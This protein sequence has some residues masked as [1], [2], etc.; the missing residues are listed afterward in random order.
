MW[1]ETVDLY[2]TQAFASKFLL[3]LSILDMFSFNMGLF[4][5]LGYKETAGMCYV[6]ERRIE[7]VTQIFTG[8]VQQD[9]ATERGEC[10]VRPREAWFYFLLTSQTA[11]VFKLRCRGW[12][13]KRFS[14]D[15]RKTNTKVNTPTNYNGSKQ[16]DEPIRF[17]SNYTVL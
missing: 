8:R 4:V 5:G 15:C 14:N 12:F 11:F 7:S 13:I 2:R 3:T 9:L 10:L 6:R 16:R 1:L 17:H